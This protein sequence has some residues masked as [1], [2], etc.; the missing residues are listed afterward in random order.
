MD[1]PKLLIVD[2]DESILLSM[3]WAFAREYEVFLASGR[4]EALEIF[5]S[6]HPPL[7]T[8]DLG[9]PPNPQGV[10]EGF[11]TLAGLVEEDPYVKVIIVSGQGDR[12]NALTA[13]GQGAYDFFCKP[14][15]VEEVSV[16]L[17][18]ALTL[19]QL[20]SE[21]RE[22]QAA[23][24]K[25][26]F[27]EL[28]G[29]S[30]EMQRVFSMIEKVAATEAPIL[31]TGES[32]TGKELVA[33]ALH[34]RSLRKA[35]PFEPIN[36][37]AIPEN[38]LESELFG[39]EKGAFTGAHAQRKGRIEMAEKGTL[40]LDEI[41]DL[42]LALQ[43][44]LL[45]FLQ[46]HKIERVGGRKP[47][48]IDTRVIAATNTDLDEAIRRGVFREDLYYRLGVVRI[49]VPPLREREG[50]IELLA[51]SF[52]N[53]YSEEHKKKVLGITQRGLNVLKNHRWPGNVRELENRIRRAV[54]MAQGRKISHEDLEL[55]TQSQPEKT[56]LRE[57]REKTDRELV[58][59]VLKNN[60][61]NLAKSA[62]DLGISRPNLY[63][64]MEKLGIR[65]EVRN[66]R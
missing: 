15:Q 17:R 34:G 39:H 50:D 51:M 6:E 12:Q 37:A 16:I 57:A 62:V 18:R 23:Q 7:V 66:S 38:L 29:A 21:N 41:G 55:E 63:E 53:K 36:C 65:K 58:L 35:G 47:I 44:K 4:Q 8:L 14:V 3:K 43:V 40:F 59:R 27:D 64:L 45:R 1:K 31:I 49:E 9:L 46:E 48:I 24:V 20:E 28:V 2:D 52:L 25:D 54:I 56:T 60:N 26:S 32:G 33:R 11:L 61:Y 10:E 30:P 42:P 5:R 22:L 13:V 19:H